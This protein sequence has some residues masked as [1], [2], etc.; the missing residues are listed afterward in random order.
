MFCSKHP[1]KELDLYCET[2]EELI[3]QHC[4]I[5]MHRDHQY[6]LVPDA[7]PKHKDVIVSSLQP[8]EQQ[9]ETVNKA[10]DQFDTQSQNIQD[11]RETLAKIIHKTIKKLQDLLETR[12]MELIAQLDQ[13]TQK[14]LKNLAAQ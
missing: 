9:L 1:T 12:K 3:C 10:L 14:K 7:F 8:V 4:I 11:Q 5:H 13:I 6:N 2:C